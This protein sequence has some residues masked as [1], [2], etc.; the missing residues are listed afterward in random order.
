LERKRESF[1]K[2]EGGSLMPS[3]RKATEQLTIHIFELDEEIRLPSTRYQGSKAKLVSWIW[4]KIKNIEFD[5]AIDIFGG[6]GVVGYFLK[7][8]GKQVYYNDYLKSNYYIGLALI[9][10][11][12]VKLSEQEAEKLLIRDPFYSYS[13]F[14]YETFKDIYYTDDENEWLDL[15]VQN[16]QRMDNI[17]KKAL[18]YYALFQAC[19][20][21]RPFNL[22]H[23]RNLYLRF[24]SVRRTFGNK[25]TWDRPFVEH[26]RDF[27][28]EVNSLV[29]D[30]R[31]ENKA[32][33]LDV[34]DVE[35]NFDLVYIDPPYTS[36]KGVI[37]DYLHF[38]H[39]LEGLAD[40]ENWGSK[41]NHRTKNKSFYKI[42]NP[43]NDKNKIR[44]KFQELF[45]KFR[46]SILV[47]SYRADGIPSIEQI[48]SDVKLFKKDVRVYTYDNYKYALSNARTS[49]V[50]IVGE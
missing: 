21:K 13:N 38:Y 19:L 9:E 10:N 29:Y 31:K 3:K 26:F 6:T 23:R 1:G 47:I 32:F 16:I 22:F 25:A 43:W 2:D 20:V 5:T 12:T 30:N 45:A 50:L 48:V 33:N 17:Y 24:A 49:E 28:K 40:Y 7:R 8:K 46:N 15:V 37:V 39:F 42:Y 27:I 35:G 34:F 14:I 4:E 18:A 41:I 44:E 36:A 11:N